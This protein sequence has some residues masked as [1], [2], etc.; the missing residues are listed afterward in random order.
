MAIEPAYKVTCGKCLTV[1]LVED[2]QVSRDNGW[3]IPRDG[4]APPLC[5]E[6]YKK[7]FE[8]LR[9]G[10]IMDVPLTVLDVVE[11]LQ[12]AYDRH[13]EVGLTNMAALLV[14]ARAEIVRLRGMVQ[15]KEGVKL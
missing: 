9:A 7:H 1:V 14:C 15:G 6:C 5:P 11:A 3:S 13:T 4:F 10:A 2:L 8:P 12:E